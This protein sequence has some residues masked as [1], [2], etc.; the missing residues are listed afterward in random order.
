MDTRARKMVGHGAIVLFIAMVA[1]FG[2]LMSLIGGFEVVPGTIIS[3]HIPGDT[4]A[5][6]RTHVGGL[7]NGMLVIVFA[8]FIHAAQLPEPL[9]R[10]LSWMLVGTGYANT[11]F[12]WGAMFAPSRSLTLGDNRLGNTNLVG[13][14]VGLPGLVFAI[15]LMIAMVV[16]VRWAFSR[17]ASSEH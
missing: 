14:L 3:F 12:F 6:A 4:S 7:M 16:V 13:T 10:R 1:G 9:A 2:L 5:W 17:V 15:V 8:L 11:A